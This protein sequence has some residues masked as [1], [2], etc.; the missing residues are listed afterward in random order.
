MMSIHVWNSTLLDV[1][2]TTLRQNTD[3]PAYFLNFFSM[4]KQVMVLPS[5]VFALART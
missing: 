2:M 4:V 1:T 5:F 3:W